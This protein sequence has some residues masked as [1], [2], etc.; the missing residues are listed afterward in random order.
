M[1]LIWLSLANYTEMNAGRDRMRPTW[2]LLVCNSKLDH[3][4]ADKHD[5]QIGRNKNS[6]YHITL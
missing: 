1:E 6:C 5:Y 2:W 4:V 3:Q